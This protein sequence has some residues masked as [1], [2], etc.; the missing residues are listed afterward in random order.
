MRENFARRVDRHRKTTGLSPRTG[1]GIVGV[2][3]MTEGGRSCVSG[4]ITLLN[5]TT[6]T[7]LFSLLVSPVVF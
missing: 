4:I 2:G 7:H 1:S 3:E 5:T 6:S